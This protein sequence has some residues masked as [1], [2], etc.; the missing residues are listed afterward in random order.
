[1]KRK[2][3]LW[4]CL[5]TIAVICLLSFSDNPPDG[6]TGAPGELT[7]MAVGCHGNSQAFDGDIEFF[8]FPAALVA[9]QTFEVGLNINVTDGQP[10]R[11]GFQ[12]VGV[13]EGPNGFV[14]VG[15][16]TDPGANVRLVTSNNRMYMEHRDAKFFNGSS[17]V[18]Y[19]ARWSTPNSF[20]VESLTLYA[21]SVLANGNGSSSGDK[22]IFQTMTLPVTNVTDEDGDGFNTDL[23]CD[24]TN[25]DINPNAMEIINNDVD[26]D[27]DGIA[28]MIDEDNDGF[29]SDEDCDDFDSNIKPGA[30]EIPNNDIDENCDG[31]VLIIDEDMDGFNSDED[32]DDTDASV[33]PDAMEI[34]NNDVD[35]NCDGIIAVV[36]NDDDG[37]HAGV[38]C[39]DKN[40]AINPDAF[41]VPDNGVDEN[42]DGIDATLTVTI[43]GTL[44]NIN[45]LPI[46][47]VIIFDSVSFTP[48]DTT[49]PDGTFELILPDDSHTLTFAKDSRAG[50][51]LSTGD[52]VVITN[53][54]LNRRP[55]THHLQSEIADVNGSGSVSS[56]DLVLIKQVILQRLPG[57]PDRPS[58]NFSPASI[59]ADQSIQNIR[60]F[61]LKLGDVNATASRQ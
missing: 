41:D 26:E 11:A 48:L 24:D 54:I 47:N 44:V 19:N 50:D 46:A 43:T 9:G 30:P 35:E 57:F 27:C 12:I 25:P 36:D 45:N 1:M 33:N 8:G 6:R 18:T 15:E 28:Q 5:S 40:A 42:C 22:V 53:H 58:W 20:Q 31:V 60:V 32:C 23:D 4:S 38:D 13:G 56:T 17:R 59:R 39:D 49:G 21:V 61:A 29:N 14:N 55:F 2:K 34:Q 51:G 16:F 52:L 7:C 10:M 37:F 3:L